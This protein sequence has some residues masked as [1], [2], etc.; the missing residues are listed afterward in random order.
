MTDANLALGRLDGEAFLGGGMRLDADKGRA[1]IGE[2]VARP[3]G[4]GV[5][6]AAEG[7]LAV[8]NANLGGAIRLSLFEKGLDPRDFAMI[9]FGGAAGLH[10][11]AVADELGIRRVV[12]P[13]SA[14]H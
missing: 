5:E 2:H 6:P 1:T 10:A 9:A 4:L 8:T 12:F 14:S 7:L 13:E 3:L 11:V